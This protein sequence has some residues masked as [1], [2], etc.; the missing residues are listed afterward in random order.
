[1]S[2]KQNNSNINA[3]EN[4][5]FRDLFDFIWRLKWWIVASAFCALLISFVYIRMQNPVF[6]RTSWIML[7]RDDGSTGELSVLTQMTGS[8]VRKKIDNELFILKSPSLMKKVVEEL[9]LNTRYYQ[10]KLPVGDDRFSF[11]RNVIPFNTQVEF[12]KDNPFELKI[13]ADSLRPK[14]HMP[15]SVYIKFKNLGEDDNKFVIK[16]A[17]VG[18]NELNTGDTEFRYGDTLVL[19]NIKVLISKTDIGSL[20][21]NTK[22]ICSWVNSFKMAESLASN[23]STEVQGNTKTYSYLNS[24]DVVLVRLTDTKPQRADDILNTLILRNNEESRLYTNMSNINTINFIDERLSEIS[25]ELENAEENVKNYQ[26]KNTVVDLSSQ[27]NLTLSSDKKYQDQLTEVQVQKR[28]LS[29]IE[30]QLKS[31]PQGEYKVIPAN[32]GVSDPGLNT[33]IAQYNTLVAERNRMIANSSA[34]NPRVLSMSSSL[35]DS[36][37]SIEISIVNLANIYSIREREL[38]KNLR[39]SQTTMESM[40]RQQQEIQ[41]LSRKLEIIEPLYLMLQQ[42]REE[43]QIS[44]YEQQ[45]TFR[46]IESSFGS[47]VP[48]SPKSVQIY[49]L[50]LILG[51]CIPPALSYPPRHH[52]RRKGGGADPRPADG[53]ERGRGRGRGG[54]KKTAR[55]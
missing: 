43:S 39:Q 50:A 51:C 48:V 6:L 3:S 44:V 42:K 49:L 7:N 32:V 22:Y 18:P 1:M 20:Q 25:S 2:E 55:P 16:K 27:A 23:I 45:D 54:S 12:Y 31:T 36:K 46:I 21:P 13:M 26:T 30:D 29:M 38:Q 35:E 52:Q 34:S 28:I 4:I 40:P 47:P 41:Q 17:F 15:R 24:C 19:G 33:V 9:E 53:A 11:L 37:K 10:V 5:S 14:S 8:R